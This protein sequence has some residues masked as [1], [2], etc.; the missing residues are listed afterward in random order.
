MTLKVQGLAARRMGKCILVGAG[1]TMLASTGVSMVL[2]TMMNAEKI[3]VTGMGYG[4]M[5]MQMLAAYSGGYTACQM[6]NEQRL[7]TALLTGMVYFAVLVTN[8]LLFFRGE[9]NGTG[10]TALLILC[11]SILS[12]MWTS[13]KKGSGKIKKL[14]FSNG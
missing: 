1:V 6:R 10:E 11:G 13:R 9:L 2:A 5:L 8:N 12:A 7:P 14:K 4:V 3:T